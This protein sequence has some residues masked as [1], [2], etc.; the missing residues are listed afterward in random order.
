MSSTSGVKSGDLL[1]EITR[2]RL[3]LER[4]RRSRRAVTH[5]RD[6]WRERALAAEWG[7]KQ[8]ERRTQAGHRVT[9]NE[10]IRDAA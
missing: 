8:L 4:S 10:C 6:Q 3:L 2:L 7:L 9:V 5:S 1:A